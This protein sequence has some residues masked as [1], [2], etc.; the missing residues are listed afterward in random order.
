MSEERLE[1]GIV[2]VLAVYGIKLLA[3][4]QKSLVIDEGGY[5]IRIELAPG[6]ATSPG[7]ALGLLKDLIRN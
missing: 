4:A 7:K 2:S 5:G 3:H 1:G 6:P